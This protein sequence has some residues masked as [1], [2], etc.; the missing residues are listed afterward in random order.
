MRM[1]VDRSD[2]SEHVE[3][4]VR[5]RHY[6]WLPEGL[7]DEPVDEAMAYIVADVMH[8]CKMPV[9][10]GKTSWPAAVTA[11]TAKKRNSTLDPPACLS[12]T[13]SDETC[14]VRRKVV[15]RLVSSV[16]LRPVNRLMDRN[17]V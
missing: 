16:L 11:S 12:G 17:A 3:S 9:S 5:S 10:L 6:T 1:A 2:W 7:G 13:V 14:R 15:V 4:V 8:V